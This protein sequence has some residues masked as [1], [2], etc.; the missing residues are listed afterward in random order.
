LRTTNPIEGVSA[1]VRHR[2]VVN[3][4]QADGFQAGYRRI[5][6]LARLK[7]TNQLPNVIAGVRSTDGIEVFQIPA[8]HAA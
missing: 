5:K 3:D 2:T 8:N 1:A 4:R 6:N 7:G